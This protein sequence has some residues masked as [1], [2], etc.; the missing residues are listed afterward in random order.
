MKLDWLHY[1]SG[2]AIPYNDLV[3]ALDYW[4]NKKEGIYIIWR[5]ET[6][7]GDEND[8]KIVYVGQGDLKVRLGVHLDDEVQYYADDELFVT[9]AEVDP[10]DQNGIEN[11]LADL[12]NPLVGDEWPTDTPIEVN[13]PD[14]IEL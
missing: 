2:N 7:V 1:D 13:L 4:K 3:L 14:F 8:R 6:N 11:F 12:L 9:W 10:D 5:K